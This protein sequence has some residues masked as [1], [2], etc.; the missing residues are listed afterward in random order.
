MSNPIRVSRPPRDNRDA[1]ASNGIEPALLG[2]GEM[3]SRM[4]SFDW[5]GSDLGT[6]SSWPQSLKNSVSLCLNAP[7]NP[8]DVKLLR[9]AQHVLMKLGVRSRAKVGRKLRGESWPTE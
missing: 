9:D 6:T 5:S 1:F 3:G 8:A 7:D 2:G 4:R